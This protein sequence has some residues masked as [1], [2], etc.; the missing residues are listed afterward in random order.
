MNSN[1]I[2]R[3]VAVRLPPMVL[4]MYLGGE[5]TQVVKSLIGSTTAQL[6]LPAVI[7]LILGFYVLWR[8]FTK[9]FKIPIA[10]S[11][12]L[13]FLGALLATFGVSCLLSAWIF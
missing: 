8:A 12:V 7:I 6:V 1:L 9:E 3:R 4:G 13:Y 10:L 11:A 2:L 5:I